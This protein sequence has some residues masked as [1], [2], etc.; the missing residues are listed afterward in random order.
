VGRAQRQAAQLYAAPTLVTAP[1]R[2]RNHGSPT[3]QKLEI[4]CRLSP[5]LDSDREQAQV[6]S[7]LTQI[8]ADYVSQLRGAL[9]TLAKSSR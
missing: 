9:E 4:L 3:V 6:L 2:C 1:L 8:I 5:M 7:V